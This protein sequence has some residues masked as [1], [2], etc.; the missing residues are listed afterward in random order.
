MTHRQE[1]TFGTEME[2]MGT[3]AEPGWWVGVIHVENT[4]HFSLA[5]IEKLREDSPKA[6]E[7]HLFYVVQ[8]LK[9]LF[10]FPCMFSKS[11]WD[12]LHYWLFPKKIWFICI[13]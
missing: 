11:F 12:D 7:N 5:L 10:C 6:E 8:V 13:H 1:K 2:I 3:V 4:Q 9:Q